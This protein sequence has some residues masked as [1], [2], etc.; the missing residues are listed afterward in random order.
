MVLA[1]GVPFTCS[2]AVAG[3]RRHLKTCVVLED[4]AGVLT[5]LVAGHLTP[6]LCGALHWLL[7]WRSAQGEENSVQLPETGGV[8]KNLQTDLKAT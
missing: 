3:G 6:L 1:Q 8:S 7:G 5:W 2:Q 4:P